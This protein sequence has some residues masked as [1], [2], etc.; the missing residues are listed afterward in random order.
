MVTFDE[1]RAA[2]R[3]TSWLQAFGKV[4]AESMT[5]G[6]I[7]AAYGKSFLAGFESELLSSSMYEV[8][9]ALVSWCAIA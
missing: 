1:I 9:V 8:Y 6:A 5:H 2:G 7:Y 3:T 4:V